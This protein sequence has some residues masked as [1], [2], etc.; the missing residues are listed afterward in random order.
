MNIDISTAEKKKQIYELFDSFSKI[1]DI[2]NYFGL[3]DTSKNIRYI[4]EIA[5]LIGFDL[6]IY[7]QRKKKYCLHCD[8]ELVSGQKK[9]CSLSCAAT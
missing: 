1:G 3:R 7:K 8:K 9:F 5:T 2:Y 6:S 4:R